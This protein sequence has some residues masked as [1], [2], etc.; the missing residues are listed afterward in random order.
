MKNKVLKVMALFVSFYISAQELP[1]VEKE[2]PNTEYF[3][4]EG[5]ENW[6]YDYDI[7]NLEDGKYNLIIRSRDN[8]GNMSIDGPVNIFVDSESDKP[9][10]S[11]SSPSPYMRIGGNLSIV[12]T[13][14]DDD[15]IASVEVKIDDSAYIKAKGTHFWSSILNIDSV[16]DGRHIITARVTDVN[17]LEGDETSVI[18][19]LDRN[20]PLITIDSHSNGEIL[21]GKKNISGFVSDANGVSRLEYS[22]DGE[23]YRELKLSGKPEQ[24]ERKFSLSVDTRESEGGTAYIRFRTVDG[25]GSEG[26][27]VF[28]YY[29]DNE[30]PVINIISPVE[31][32]NLNGFVT[33]TGTVSDEVGI[34][35]FSYSF[36]NEENVEIP[37]IAGNPYWSKSFDVGENKNTQIVFKAIDLSGNNEEYKLKVKLTPDEDKPLVSFVDFIDGTELAS[38]QILKGIATDDDGVK[39]IN[40]TVDG[41]D[42]QL[43]DTEGPFIL[44]FSELEPG[45][46]D[47]EVFAIDINDVAGES[48]N[49]TFDILAE[50]PQIFLNDYTTDK[51]VEPFFDGII[52]QQGK[53]AKIS[54]S[55]HDGE[56][57]IFV[58][59]LIDGVEGK[60]VKV[61]RGV[62]S[63]T[64]P[65]K[66][67]VGGH[68]IELK[69]VD[70]LDRMSVI[71]SRIY[72]APSPAKGEEYI[73]VQQDSP[74]LFL[75]DAR[76][77]NNQIVNMTV[78]T[79]IT[80]YITGDT[81]KTVELVPPQSHFVASKEGNRFSISPVSDSGESA[82]SLKVTTNSGKEY[83]SENIVASS[84]FNR[85]ILEVESL[86]VPIEISSKTVTA[87]DSI[88][89]NSDTI[90]VDENDISIEKKIIS[91][92]I[93]QN[94]LI[95]KGRYSDANKIDRAE[96]SF[97]GSA[98][99]YGG[100]RVIE[101]EFI[102]GQYRFNQEI[103]LLVLPEGE[104]FV[105]ISVTDSLNNSVRTS[106][107][108]IIDRSPPVLTIL[109]PASDV[110][111]E[112]IITVTGKIEEFIGGGQV[113]FSENGIDFEE[114][115][116]SSQIDFSHNVDLSKVDSDPDK[117]LYRVV[118]RGRNIKELTPQF[119]VDLEAD[120]PTVAIEVPAEESTIR[121]DF[122]VTGLVFDDDAVDKIFFSL[123]GSDFEEI[124]GNFYYNI[125]F[126]ISNIDD[127][128]HTIAVKAQDS[129]GFMS[130]EAT[131]VFYIS[132]AEPVSELLSPMIDEY[133]TETILLE[134]ET[135]DENGV[136]EIFIS[137][138]NGISYN[139]AVITAIQTEPIESD[140]IFEE[141]TVLDDTVE[142]EQLLSESI[143]T[144]VHWEY[145]FDTRL[146][147]DGTHS[148]LIKAID[149][150]GTVGIS[151]TI[152]N[153]DNTKP[154]IKLDTPS[155]SDLV[156]G[157]LIIDGKVFDGTQI[158]SV[159]C[160]LKALDN[161]DFVGLIKEIKTEG[162]FRDVFDVKDYEPGWYNLN[163]T[164]TDYADNS[165]SETRNLQIAPA[166]AGEVIDLYFPEEGKDISGPFVVEGQLFSRKGIGKVLLKVD[167]TIVDTSDIDHTGLFSFFVNGRDLSEGKHKISV[168]TNDSETAIDSGIRNIFYT[169]IGPWVL[170]DNMTSGQFVSRRPMI[171]GSAGFSG[172]EEDKSKD[173][174]FV[175]VSLDNGRIFSK[176][177]GKEEWQFRLETYDLPEGENQLLIRAHFKDG[178]STITKLFV[179]VDETAPIV[180]LFTP[181]EN[182]KFNG[183]VPLVGT[184]SDENG[185]SGVEVLIRKGS[186]ERY[187]VPSFI[188][189]LY[190]DFHAIGQTYGELGVGL[191]FF[192][193]V[194]KLQAQVGLAPPGRFEGLV[195]GVK[196]LATVI[197]LPFS[198]FFGY[199]WE[200]FS[201]SLAVGANFNFYTMSSDGYYITKE[202]VVLGSVLLQYEFAKF[203]LNDKKMFNSYSF[204]VEGGLNFISS[205]REAGV[206]PTLSFGA[207]I[208]IF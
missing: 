81:I 87:V 71:S 65:S 83:N 4:V 185:L 125:P 13:A 100:S 103:D 51:T 18:V 127:G 136:D 139:R 189:G 180:H 56:G 118:D 34:E 69:A 39:N 151:S 169:A 26:S 126:S 187:E 85:P 152:L 190:I 98:S 155:D 176:A 158:K 95:L 19:N 17:G 91:T 199:D 20:K 167:D 57:D 11:I 132:K 168:V 53:T 43:L 165:I 72:F 9:T 41:T 80:G 204:Y 193:D 153:I 104:H 137:Y 179:N 163:I 129:G 145:L 201:M 115:H 58:S 70:S 102:D 135:Y 99:S 143:E 96:I 107:P 171:E 122:S 31:E 119:T 123:D 133:A 15:E 124:E 45:K 30:K 200:F 29:G 24:T 156:T 205:D 2:S 174:E 188:Q 88:D 49:Y 160:E 21:S 67:E 97:S 141:E 79:P 5:L 25:T 134:G 64:I 37:L 60:P 175:E 35:S 121:N 73:P 52:F 33:V 120:R 86:Q 62:F 146:P 94:T 50:N 16:G 114:L 78:E 202:G 128:F 162:V 42:L 74:Q 183:S 111:V 8:A 148:I 159:V 84:D 77:Q 117:F 112:G 116:M 138:D 93:I 76:L 54:G 44:H 66:L 63:I 46:H 207:R 142:G 47:I 48:E 150:A 144:T 61:S 191:S 55:V 182:R 164:V 68:D 172:F 194:V 203:E 38:D 23:T 1:E 173:V 196:L 170:V 195:F 59:Y 161:P 89:E 3:Q 92:N 147:G 149:G 90:A 36:G 192:D 27:N 28:V 14:A 157:K 22:L 7:S 110:P 6:T 75:I 32:D 198:Y 208:G 178:S 177:K 108:F 140:T 181:E 105:T 101:A 10:V 113:F 40:Y 82:F 106:I 184:A 154:E 130:N 109:S 206:S 166:D 131:T 197:D 12:G 186:K